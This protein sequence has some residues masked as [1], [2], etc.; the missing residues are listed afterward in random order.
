VL[1]QLTLSSPEMLEVW[2][3]ALGGDEG[4]TLLE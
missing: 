2:R 1:E 4:A 3:R